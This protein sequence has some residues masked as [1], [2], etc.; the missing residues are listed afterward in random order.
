MIYFLA[1]YLSVYALLNLYVFRWLRPA[2]HWGLMGSLIFAGFVVVM[3]A[4]TFMIHWS[5]RHDW[6]L[7]SQIVSAF[8]YMWMM[9]V[10]W[11]FTFGMPAEVWNLFVAVFSMKFQA[12]K[13]LRIVPDV[14]VG[15]MAIISCLLTVWG[16]FE[17]RNI[18]LETITIQTPK[19][20][21][22]TPPMKILQMSDLHLGPLVGRQRVEK[23][24]DLIRKSNPD[25]LVCT[26]DMVDSQNEERMGDHAVKFALLTAAT[27]RFAVLG[28]HEFY[29]GVDSSLYLL[30]LAGFKV[31][32]EEHVTV[33]HDGT[34]IV[35]AGV[36]DSHGGGTEVPCKSN[37]DT[38]LPKDAN[39]PY[40]ILLKHQPIPSRLI[41]RFDLQLSAHTHGG[42]V[43][44]FQLYVWLFYR[45][46][47][48]MRILPDG[49]LM[50]V[51]PGC[52]TW[53]P[54]IRVLAPPELTLFVI[55]PKDR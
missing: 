41:G 32:R 34:E 36:D 52:G 26:G 30:K 42:Q 48:G 43:F 1:I 3:T 35:I 13:S 4:M 55:E 51:N 46:L 6:F 37:E 11:I 9:V 33:K 39:R 17:V 15:A 22:G 45:N 29:T 21:K 18:R 10:V 8:A 40:T 12:M 49:S 50:Y 20:P 54:P 25:V 19:F 28:N 2:F 47:R 14:F 16:V 7:T 53:G 31:L 24:L 38:A 44:P 5:E 23:V 27:N